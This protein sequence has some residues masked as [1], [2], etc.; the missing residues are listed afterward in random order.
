M[1][2]YGIRDVSDFACFRMNIPLK[3]SWSFKPLNHMARIFI[4]TRKILGELLSDTKF[5]F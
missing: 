3:L 5:H 1:T 4:F 2:A